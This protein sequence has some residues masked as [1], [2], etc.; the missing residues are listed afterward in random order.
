[1][2]RHFVKIKPNYFF[3]FTIHCYF[4]SFFRYYSQNY[5]NNMKYIFF[6]IEAF[7]AN[8]NGIL[9]DKI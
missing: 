8:A 3:Y 7:D 5:S 4:I 1:M 9:P 2:C 6:P